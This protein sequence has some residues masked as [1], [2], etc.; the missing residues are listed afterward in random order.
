MRKDFRKVLSMVL[1]LYAVG[2]VCGHATGCKPPPPQVYTAVEN[3][4]A[5]AQYTALLDDCRR[6]GRAAGSYAVYETCANAV[7]DHLCAQ[8]RLRCPEDR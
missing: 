8:H 4:A 2:F 1:F 7:D 6:Q 5:V 3:A